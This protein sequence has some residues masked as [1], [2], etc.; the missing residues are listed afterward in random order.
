VGWCCHGKTSRLHAHAHPV[1]PAPKPWFPGCA[2]VRPPPQTHT[3]P[4][5]PP[6]QFIVGCSEFPADMAA[7]TFQGMDRFMFAGGSRVA[8]LCMLPAMFGE[9]KGDKG[10]AD[11]GPTSGDDAKAAL[12]RERG[13]ARLRARAAAAGDD[14]WAYDHE[15]Y[16]HQNVVWAEAMRAM[17]PPFADT[18]AL[19]APAVVDEV[20]HEVFGTPTG[21][22]EDE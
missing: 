15:K 3:H 20:V 11:D 5:P 16:F 19:L 22:C 17:G 6:V 21:P 13:E 9:D 7:S 12:L 2:F 8:D 10:A 1:L 18:A 4:R 14:A